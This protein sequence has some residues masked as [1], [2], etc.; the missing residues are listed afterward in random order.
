MPEYLGPLAHVVVVPQ[1]LAVLGDALLGAVEEI[2]GLSVAL[3]THDALQEEVL[4]LHASGLVLGL[5]GSGPGV[6]RFEESLE[7]PVEAAVLVAAV[8]VPLRLPL[9]LLIMVMNIFIKDE[10]EVRRRPSCCCTGS[11]RS[12]SVR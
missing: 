10:M 8:L 5:A 2:L 7:P 12:G 11:L 3:R 9:H 4:V 1:G 6:Q